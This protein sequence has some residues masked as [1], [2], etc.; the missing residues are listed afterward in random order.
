MGHEPIQDPY[1]EREEAKRNFEQ[2]KAEIGSVNS[3]LGEPFNGSSK[4]QPKASVIDE[5]EASE[6]PNASTQVDAIEYASPNLST[7][8]NLEALTL[9]AVPAAQIKSRNCCR[10]KLDR[11]RA[12]ATGHRKSHLWNQ[13]S[14]P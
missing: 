11:A 8:P 7:R 6:V 10:Q 4:P 1:D 12:M 9:D 2:L 5:E 3:G 13:C 14:S